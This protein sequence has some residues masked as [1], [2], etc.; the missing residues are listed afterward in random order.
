MPPKPGHVHRSGSPKC[1][2]GQAPPTSRG[3]AA[4]DHVPAAAVHG[5][6]LG[7]AVFRPTHAR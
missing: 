2:S 3:G 7:S 6:A 4:V 1:L 5:L